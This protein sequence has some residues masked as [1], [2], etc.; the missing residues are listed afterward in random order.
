MFSRLFVATTIFAV[1][2]ISGCAIA[3]T[4][5][6]QIAEENVIEIPEPLK[7]ILSEGVWA[8]YDDGSILIT[9]SYLDEDIDAMKYLN[10][11]YGNKKPSY[12]LAIQQRDTLRK[13]AKSIRD[14][15]NEIA[16]IFV[17][18]HKYEYELVVI[19]YKNSNQITFVTGKGVPVAYIFEP[20]KR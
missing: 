10:Q 2:F 7:L 6:V 14:I 20:S 5:K 18:D 13:D 17:I 1:F 4:L 12:K 9:S 11:I 19:G 3:N 16:S 15:S 8:K